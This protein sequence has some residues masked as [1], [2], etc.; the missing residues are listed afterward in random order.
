MVLKDIK[1]N[2]IKVECCGRVFLH[3]NRG[4]EIVRCIKCLNTFKFK[5]I[6]NAKV[7]DSIDYVAYEEPVNKRTVANKTP[8]DEDAYEEE[9]V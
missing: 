8:K 5:D 9:L 2:Y 3:S 1:P 4:N 7:G 6:K